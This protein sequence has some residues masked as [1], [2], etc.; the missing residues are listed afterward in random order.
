LAPDH[1]PATNNGLP[2][3]D[4]DTSPALHQTFFQIE[5][6]HG[7][8]RKIAFPIFATGSNIANAI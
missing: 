6:Y 8:L 5:L 4:Q 1:Q 7:W 2:Y 3:H